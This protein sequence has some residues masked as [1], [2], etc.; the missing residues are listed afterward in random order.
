[1]IR[2]WLPQN[3]ILA[4][5]NV[6][7]FISHGGM[8]G[9]FEAIA[10]GKPLL[11][12]PFFGDQSRNAIRASNAG[13]ARYLNFNEITME[14]LYSTI[15]ELIENPTYANKAKH[16]SVL[17]SDNLVHPMDEAIYWIEYVCRHRG[18][19]HLKSHAVNMSWFSY[20]LLD[21]LLVNLLIAILIVLGL[22]FGFKMMCRGKNKYEK[23]K[24]N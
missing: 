14:L 12:I 6:V 8:F 5:K 15:L 13:Y 9:H 2:K 19:K 21:V 11:M 4:H 20:L 7:L 18:A 10:R 1:M 24:I 3:D 23:P 17:Y 22:Y 16:M